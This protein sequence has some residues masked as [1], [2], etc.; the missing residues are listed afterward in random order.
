MSHKFE[1]LTHHDPFED[2]ES[3]CDALHKY[4]KNGSL[5]HHDPFEDTERSQNVIV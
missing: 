1:R 5:T 4:V 3:T 2:T